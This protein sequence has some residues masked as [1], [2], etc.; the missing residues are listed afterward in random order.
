MASRKKAKNQNAAKKTNYKGPFQ[1]NRNYY[2]ETVRR[3]MHMFPDGPTLSEMTELDTS[4]DLFKGQTNERN[5][6]KRPVSSQTKVNT[7]LQEHYKELIVYSI[8]IPLIGYILTE[9]VNHK[10]KLAT[11]S[12]D[13]EHVTKK[14]E[15]NHV[16]IN[17]LK[18]KTNVLDR[19]VRLLEQRVDLS[20][21]SK[22]SNAKVN[23]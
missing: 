1:P 7:W 3:D 13:I 22:V 18:E 15:D 17:L 10:V 12:S 2:I 9:S 8:L 19:D 11:H 5:T 20:K 4:Q 23:K 14:V 21:D 16:D 6:E